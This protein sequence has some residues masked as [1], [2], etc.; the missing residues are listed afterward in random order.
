M[1]LRVLSQLSQTAGDTL[2][3]IHKNIQHNTKAGKKRKRSGIPGKSS[4]IKKLKPTSEIQQQ[5]QKK[6]DDLKPNEHLY[7]GG[8]ILDIKKNL[9]QAEKDPLATV[10]K[11]YFD[12]QEDIRLCFRK[13][14]FDWIIQ[15]HSK[16]KLRPDTLYLAVS[17]FDRYMCLKQIARTELQKLGSCCLFISSKYHDIHCLSA[18]ML[19]N[20]ADGAFD[21]EALLQCEEQVVH[22][23]QFSLTVPT[24]LSFLQI[25]L[26]LKTNHIKYKRI[27]MG[28]KYLCECL[29]FEATLIEKVTP[30]TQAAIA[31]YWALK[32]LTNETWDQELEVLSEQ[33][34]KDLQGYR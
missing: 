3:P 9:I 18:Q 20:L 5:I 27:E 24:S 11:N 31:M 8:V 21:Y 17:L 22:T 23:L 10:T 33:Q 12:F 28:A 26:M 19:V 16:L 32:V 34:G 30:S 6:F 29:L 25:L 7:C 2:N 1:S 15:V 4:I 14:L 13:R